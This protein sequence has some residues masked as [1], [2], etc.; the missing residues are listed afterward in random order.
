MVFP[1]HRPLYICKGVYV[2]EASSLD[3]RVNKNE[4]IALWRQIS[5]TSMWDMD[6]IILCSVSDAGL[7]VSLYWCLIDIWHK[8]SGEI[9]YAAPICRTHKSLGHSIRIP[10]AQHIHRIHRVHGPPAFTMSNNS[11]NADFLCIVVI[12][13][14]YF[15]FAAL[16]VI[17]ALRFASCINDVSGCK[18]K[19]KGFK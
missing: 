5:L 4:N 12:W 15:L 9:R 8:T 16:H 7:K 18:W 6:I 14:P 10:V 17:Y 11:N 13:S 2:P 19:N 3:D 1:E